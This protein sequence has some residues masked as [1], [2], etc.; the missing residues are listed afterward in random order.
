M[1]VSIFQE[2]YPRVLVES[3]EY[4][5]IKGS[6]VQL[7]N[8]EDILYQVVVAF[9]HRMFILHILVFFWGGGGGGWDLLRSACLERTKITPSG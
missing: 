5:V 8:A 2:K 7:V 9:Q 1:D 6:Y 3:K 4:S